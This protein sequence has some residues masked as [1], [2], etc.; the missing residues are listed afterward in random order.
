MSFF[1][2]PQSGPP[3]T[4]VTLIFDDEVPFISSVSFNGVNAPFS[5]T[6]EGLVSTQVPMGATT[7]QIRV[8][9]FGGSL[10]SGFPFTVTQVPV[11]NVPVITSVSP[12]SGPPGTNVTLAG[13]NLQNISS[14][15]LN[16]AQCLLVSVLASQVIVTVP[17]GTLSGRI[18]LTGSS[19]SATAPVDF[20]FTQ[21]AQAP[22]VSSFSPTT[23]PVGIQVTINGMR[24]ANALQVFFNGVAASFSILSDTKIS[25]MVPAN[26][27]T[28]KISVANSFGAGA[29][30][31]N[32]VVPDTIGSPQIFSFSPV[33]GKAMDLI[34]V[35]GQ[36]LSTVTA[37]F[38]NGVPASFT[39]VS[40]TVLQARVPVNATTGK[41]KAVNP[42]GEGLSAGL[43]TVTDVALLPEVTA[44]NPPAA[45]PGVSIQIIG[46]GFAGA[47]SVVFSGNKSA[48]FSES[49]GTLI[50]AVVPE[51]AI[52]GPVTITTPVGSKMSTLSFTVGT[53]VVP[54]P[55]V[56]GFSPVRGGFNLLVTVTGSRFTNA[57]GVSFGGTAAPDF[58]VRN[59]TTIEVRVP[60][61]ARTGPITVSNAGGSGSS[62]ASFEVIQLEPTPPLIFSFSPQAGAPGTEVDILGTRLGSV[63]QASIMGMNCPILSVLNELVRIRIPDGARSGPIML[64]ALNGTAT[65]A[66]SFLV[67]G[68]PAPPPPPVSGISRIR[69][70]GPNFFLAGPAGFVNEVQPTQDDFDE[71]N[72][73]VQLVSGQSFDLDIL[74]EAPEVIKD[75]VRITFVSPDPRIVITVPTRPV[76]LNTPFN[77]RVE[78]RASLPEMAL[79]YE[80]KIFGQST[81]NP[82][83]R[84]DAYTG[85]LFVFA[86]VEVVANNN[87]TLST[88]GERMFNIDIVRRRFATAP[89]FTLE[90]LP[91][92]VSST[93]KS[94]VEVPNEASDR[95]GV[96]DKYQVLL[97]STAVAA[98]GEKEINVK[99]NL[100]PAVVRVKPDT[101]KVNVRNSEAALRLPSSERQ[102]VISRNGSLEIPFEIIPQTTSGPVVV[103]P[104]LISPNP[105]PQ[106]P[107]VTTMVKFE[108]DDPNVVPERLKRLTVMFSANANLKRGDEFDY[109][110]SL[111]TTCGTV[112]SV[113]Q[114]KLVGMV[115]SVKLE[116][117]GFSGL[118][119]V[120]S[121]EMRGENDLELLAIP[122][123]GFQDRVEVR[124]TVFANGVSIFLEPQVVDLGP[125]SSGNI[126]TLR[127]DGSAGLINGQTIVAFTPFLPGTQTKVGEEFF[128]GVITCQ[129]EDFLKLPDA[130]NVPVPNPF[131]NPATPFLVLI[132]QR[133]PLGDAVGV[134]FV[135][136]AV[137]NVTIPG[138]T[139]AP[140]TLGAQSMVNLDPG[141]VNIKGEAT[142]VATGKIRKVDLS[143]VSV[144]RFI[145][146]PGT[147]MLTDTERIKTLSES[148][149]SFT[150]TRTLNLNGFESE[151]YTELAE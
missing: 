101:F 28:G 79:P 149:Q 8:N 150:Y 82:G 5:F 7:G 122:K 145:N 4:P 69:N 86:P 42:S 47:T 85:R 60:S 139:V 108:N 9:F 138:V 61:G 125:S 64:T 74:A 66:N 148:E 104:I 131:S 48:T 73:V 49:N 78:T 97:K 128:V 34:T 93:I 120:F 100:D 102:F 52:S 118:F 19:G 58:V 18:V 147:P 39:A 143:A 110:I 67:N 91:S 45:L 57:A 12:T 3:G 146:Q 96:R 134:N 37:F 56:S 26:A 126:I 129:R 55:I 88:C 29:S 72:V 112:L 109:N 63:F 151:A 95:G 103:K 46:T 36:N 71:S 140:G 50:Q 17:G 59:D 105:A 127:V 133:L 43:F 35:N 136:Q 114:I 54:P 83:R 99:V 75:S 23:G 27:G 70:S 14:A 89:T 111:E 98:L 137:Q 135:A 2:T 144:I 142:L 53:E 77:V 132:A 124:Q 84:Y 68:M 121:G 11:V 65:T 113:V 123:D 24:F 81:V 25:A 116:P 117:Q 62:A 20:I 80:I 141:F 15:T 119:S 1:F 21:S 87:R 130:V 31:G 16:N 30:V 38:F 32:F 13:A 33:S 41:L 6:L 94:V 90:N 51:G 92:G 10:S 76:A 22:V 115:G 106:P 40:N 107:V 44:F